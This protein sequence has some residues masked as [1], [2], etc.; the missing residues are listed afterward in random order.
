MPDI[1]DVPVSGLGSL[2]AKAKNARDRLKD[3][4]PVISAKCI[5]YDRSVN[6]YLIRLEVYPA[7]RQ[8]RFTDI[9]VDG[10]LMMKVVEGISDGAQIDSIFI[11][12]SPEYSPDKAQGTFGSISLDAFIVPPA[13]SGAKPKTTMFYVVPKRPMKV[14]TIHLKSAQWFASLSCDVALEDEE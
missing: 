4:S 5:D 3:V 6:A 11:W 7:K 1:P 14:A 10:C 8:Y 2:F 13:A 12:P 9:H